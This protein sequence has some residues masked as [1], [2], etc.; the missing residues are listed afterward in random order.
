[1]SW[2]LKA[3]NLTI[4]YP[5]RVV[6]QKL[7]FGFDEG[8]L[9]CLMGP[10]GAGK[11]TLLRTVAGLQAQ[12]HGSVE[13]V[14]Q[15][16]EQLDRQQRAKLI[17]LVL[18]EAPSG[19]LRVEELVALGRQPYTNWY[20]KLN[21]TD[22]S[23]VGEALQAVGIE[24]FRERRL[25]SLS[26]GQRQKALI[27]RALAQEGKLLLLDEPTAHLDLLNRIQ[28]MQLLRKLAHEQQKTIL[29]ATHELH[30]AL[31]T[32]DVLWLLPEGADTPS[33]QGLPE[34]LLLNGAIEQVFGKAGYK[35][36]KESANFNII[37]KPKGTVWV[38][39]EGLEIYWLKRALQ[40]YGF[41]LNPA[42]STQIQPEN[43]HWQL[44]IGTETQKHK[45]I[46]HLLN[47]LR[48]INS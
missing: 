18:T 22:R 6:K 11:S 40:R 23:I 36:D 45:T 1:M 5:G 43:N 31:Q 8:Q 10:N 42:A 3:N 24:E 9:V 16:L 41:E 47:V 29:V 32:A 14:G 37:E 33:I 44:K 20:G 48:H 15:S 25:S 28:I 38:E 2:V 7:N 19:N 35:F 34:D 4:G 27:A 13:I 26:D 39:G 30:L 17:S 46:N 21:P 12:L